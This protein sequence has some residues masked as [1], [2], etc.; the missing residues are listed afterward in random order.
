M[1]RVKPWVQYHQW[2]EQYGS[3]IVFLEMLFQ[4]VII[5]D[6][7]QV[8]LDLMEKRSNVY[9]DK[10]ISIMDELTGWDWNLAL[11][12]YGPTWR[13]SRRYFHQYFNQNA[14]RQYSPVQLREVRSFLRRALEPHDSIN[15]RSVSQIFSAIILNIVYGK[16]IT[17]MDDEYVTIMERG[18]EAFALSKVPGA[19]WIDSF[20]WL[21]YTPTWFPGAAARKFGKISK[22]FVLA[23]RD[24]PFEHARQSMESTTDEPRIVHK[25][26]QRITQFSDTMLYTTHEYYAKSATGT[27]YVAG[28]ETSLNTTSWFLLAM[29]MHADVQVKARQEL[30]DALGLERLPDF[31]DLDSLPYIRAIFMEVLRWRPAVPLGIPHRVMV[32]DEYNGYRIPKGSIVIANAWAMTHNPKDYT[33][34]DSF[35]PD[36]FLKDGCINRDVLDPGIAVFGFG[37]RICPGRHFVKET[38]LL[39]FASILSVFDIQPAIGKDGKPVALDAESPGSGILSHPENLHCVLKPRSA[40]AERLIRESE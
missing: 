24:L 9:S 27:A 16:E 39:T 33:N 23:I 34:P 29:A 21:R 19:F 12:R 31:D 25:L 8:A 17:S 26:L 40:A 38:L 28:V 32:E 2:A 3:N 1:P 20:P 30:D 10:P 35:D 4:P 36:R 6:S 11:L 13:G 18:S 5:L 14:V 22:P 37:R 15:F 7:V